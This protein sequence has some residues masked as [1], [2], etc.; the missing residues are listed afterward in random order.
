MSQ[1]EQTRAADISWSDG[2]HPVDLHVVSPTRI[3]VRVARSDPPP[4]RPFA[5][6][7]G[8]REMSLS[9]WLERHD[10]ASPWKIVWSPDKQIS[11]QDVRSRAILHDAGA[12]ALKKV[13]E[14]PDLVDLGVRRCKELSISNDNYLAVQAI[15]MDYDRTMQ[16]IAERRLHLQGRRAAVDDMRRR[17]SPIGRRSSGVPLRVIEHDSMMFLVV[18]GGQELIRVTD[19]LHGKLVIRSEW[20][21]DHWRISN[22][23]M[24]ASLRLLENRL[25]KECAVELLYAVAGH[26]D[27][28]ILEVQLLS[29]GLDDLAAEAGTR[30]D[31]AIKALHVDPVA[32]SSEASLGAR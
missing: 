32:P 29:E 26:V 2:L 14:H 30:M 25:R 6:R 24:Q 4:P 23:P 18:I 17:W 11:R 22:G 3:V 15:R 5:V 27:S 8:F 28:E 12:K 7:T 19:V 1:V 31:R 10:E 21:D 20:D 9:V 13:A 16:A